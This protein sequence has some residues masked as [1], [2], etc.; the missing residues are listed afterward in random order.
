MPARN[1]LPLWW[2]ELGDALHLPVGQCAKV[3]AAVVK[4]GHCKD[5]AKAENG[6]WEQGSDQ[7]RAPDLPTER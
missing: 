1:A 5:G 3:A 2:V 7:H 4:F 6:Q